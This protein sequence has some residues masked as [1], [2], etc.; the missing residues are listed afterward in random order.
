MN[1]NSEY[2]FR[3]ERLK[4]K[5]MIS[6]EDVAELF[7]SSPGR[8]ELLGNHTDHNNGKVLVTA[9]N[10]TMMAAVKRNKTNYIRA[11]FDDDDFIVID[12]SDLSFRREELG[13]SI[14][15]IRGVAA[16]F[17][18]RGYIIG[19]FDVKIDSLIP[20][21]SGVSSSAAFE[22]IFC[23]IMNELFNNKEIPLLTKAEIAQRSEIDYF[24][25]PCGLLDQMGIAYGGI[26]HIDF[27]SPNAP[28]VTPVD[29]QFKDYHL[30]LVNTLG[31]H[32]NLTNYYAEIK[33]DMF[34]IS[35]FFGVTELRK[36]NENEFYRNISSLFNNYG[37]RAILRCIH[38]FEENKRVDKAF[39][40]LKNDDINTF[41]DQ[42]NKS[43]Q[44]SYD[45]LQN[46]YY[47]GDSLQGIALGINLSQKILKHGAVRVHGGGFAGTILAIV[48]QNDLA[49][50]I[51]KMSIIY[52][53]KNIY[54]VIP[55]KI[56]TSLID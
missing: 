6:F 13:Q 55:S 29:Y 7:F 48:H 18:E 10:L 36:V 24:G 46:C 11:S 1:Q 53:Q 14:A 2:I 17:V 54:T 45:L 32:T 22:L 25:K 20:R 4:K 33:D 37:G 23:E 41:L 16:G 56:G 31:D 52:G 28:V 47:P 5:F 40:A 38:F 44:S 21:G 42:V 8:I 9:I 30:V 34:K 27:L 49:D 15:I 19:G 43:G 26:N 39:N 50:Y 3:L 35:E 51:S 12:L